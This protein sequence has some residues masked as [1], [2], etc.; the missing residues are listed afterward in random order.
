VHVQS[1]SRFTCQSTIGLLATV[2]F[3]YLERTKGYISFRESSS[4]REAGRWLRHELKSCA[5]AVLCVKTGYFKRAWRTEVGTETDLASRLK[6]GKLIVQ[7]TR[8]ELWA[9]V[10]MIGINIISTERII[11]KRT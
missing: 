7:S 2:K 9:L 10:G 5:R 3:T 6:Q 8:V 1:C 11:N 4:V